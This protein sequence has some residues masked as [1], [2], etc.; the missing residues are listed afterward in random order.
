MTKLLP[1]RASGR[2]WRCLAR[3][4][5]IKLKNKNDET[6]PQERMRPFLALPGVGRKNKIYT[7]K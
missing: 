3:A 6:P 1:G 2:S 5:K 7:Q 4:E